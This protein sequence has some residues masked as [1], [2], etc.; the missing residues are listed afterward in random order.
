MV[1]RTLNLRQ[2]NKNAAWSYALTSEGARRYE[3]RSGD[4]LSA[5]PSGTERSESYDSYKMLTGKTYQFGFKMMIEPGETNKASWLLITQLNSELDPGEA[6]HSPPFAI[7]MN[8]DKLRIVTRDSSVALS[9][10]S[11]IRYVRQY[12][13]AKPMTRGQWYELKVQVVM[14]PSG[15]G[16]LKVWRDGI[17]LVDF[18]GALGFND[19]V[20]PYFKQGIYR[21]STVQ[22]I[23]M[24]FKDLQFGQVD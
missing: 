4:D 1:L 18:A 21:S 2:Q 16:K 9:T 13:D 6:P 3:L 5:T 10:P 23:A 17:V 7:E 19:I 8:G 11:N 14:G 15:N 22:T 12:D 20:G 24:Q